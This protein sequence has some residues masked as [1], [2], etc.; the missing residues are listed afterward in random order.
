MDPT[1]IEAAQNGDRQALL[2]LYAR[3]RD[4][5]DANVKG[6]C[7]EALVLRAFELEGAEIVRPFSVQ[8]AKETVEQIDGVI[9]AAGMACIVESKCEAREVNIEPIAKLRNQLLRRPGGVIGVV[10]SDI[11]F[12]EPART[13]AQF[14]A[15][16]IIL[17]WTGAELEYAIKSQRMVAGLQ[18][19]YRIA[20]EH[21]LPDY[22]LLEESLEV[23]A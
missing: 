15:P 2:E 6:R 4:I 5:Q 20:V 1:D 14:T 18:R 17:L 12:T 19:K 21:A 23:N 9:Y 7:F 8:L 22:N 16:Q 10:F 13:L 3:L 11:G